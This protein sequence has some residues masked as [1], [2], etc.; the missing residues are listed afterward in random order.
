MQHEIDKTLRELIDTFC[1]HISII[2]QLK[3]VQINLFIDQ[4]ELFFQ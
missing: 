4:F 2:Q 1:E 3:R